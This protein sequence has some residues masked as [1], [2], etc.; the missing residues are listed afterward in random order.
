M[1]EKPPIPPLY[2]MEPPYPN[3]GGSK[4]MVR[5]SATAEIG[6]IVCH[7]KPTDGLFGIR[8]DV[9][10]P[11]VFDYSTKPP[12]LDDWETFGHIPVVSLCLSDGAIRRIRRADAD[13]YEFL[14]D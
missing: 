7:H 2:H 5:R 11:P 8:I 3:M 1:D 9:M 13:D 6:Q 4:I 10:R 14:L 12:P